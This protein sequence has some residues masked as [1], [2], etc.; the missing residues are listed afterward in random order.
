MACSG[1]WAP[2]WSA[3]ERLL[4]SPWLFE[5]CAQTTTGVTSDLRQATRYAR[6]MV[7]ECGMSDAL[8]R[9]STLV[10]ICVSYVLLQRCPGVVCAR[11][12]TAMRNC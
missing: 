5:M 9:L 7:A 11:V 1:T 10:K 8:V 12:R 6:H 3:A 4:T 2:L